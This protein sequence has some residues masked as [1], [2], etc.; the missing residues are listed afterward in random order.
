MLKLPESCF[1]LFFHLESCNYYDKESK[2]EKLYGITFN[3][4]KGKYSSFPKSFLTLV[5]HVSSKLWLP[6]GSWEFEILTNAFFLI[7]VIHFFSLAGLLFKVT[8]KDTEVYGPRMWRPIPRTWRQTY[9]H[10]SSTKS[11]R[12]QMSFE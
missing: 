12:C 10:Y 2:L 6:K 11:K 4:F 7:I 8:T 3:A 5:Y 1:V 9:K